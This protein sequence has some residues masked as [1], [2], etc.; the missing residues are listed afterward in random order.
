MQFYRQKP[1]ANFI[2]D[3]Y[4]HSVKLVIEIDGSQHYED[5]HLQSDKERDSILNDLGLLVLRFDNREVLTQI[6]NVVESIYNTVSDRQCS[7]M[8]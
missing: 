4:A 2:V 5:D 1:I 7:L 6:D 3:F 8:K